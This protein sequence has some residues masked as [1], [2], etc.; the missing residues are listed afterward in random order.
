MQIWRKPNDTLLNYE[1]MKKV[2]TFFCAAKILL[3][4]ILQKYL[5]KIRYFYF[6]K[7]IKTRLEV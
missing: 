4:I 2:K 6:F 7:K 3:F 5:A 1:V